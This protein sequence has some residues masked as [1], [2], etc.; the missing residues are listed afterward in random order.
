M[1]IPDYRQKLA[2]TVDPGWTQRVV[3][4][5]NSRDA[6][7][8][9]PQGAGLLNPLA[10]SRV[11]PPGQLGPGVNQLSPVTGFAKGRELGQNGSFDHPSFGDGSFVAPRFKNDGADPAQ[12]MNNMEAWAR[13]LKGT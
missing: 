12:D 2:A 8:V 3:P 10:Q 13:S 4:N 1:D 7:G 6:G 11:V 9:P 5:V